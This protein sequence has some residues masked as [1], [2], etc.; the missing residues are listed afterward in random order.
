M[1]TKTGKKI[2]PF[3]SPLFMS[4]PYLR[5]KFTSFNRFNVPIHKPVVN[6]DLELEYSE[7]SE[8][9]S[10]STP[11]T[12]LTPPPVTLKETKKVI[13]TDSMIRSTYIKPS[14]ENKTNENDWVFIESS[15]K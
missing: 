10:P 11:L 7:D 2:Q 1:D 9:E 4:N 13:L 6:I 8:E 14:N 15:N 12:P 3:F 5:Y